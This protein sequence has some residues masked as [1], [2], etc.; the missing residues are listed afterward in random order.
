MTDFRYSVYP[1]NYGEGVTFKDGVLR[2]G[3]WDRTY[4]MPAD[5]IRKLYKALKDHYEPK[6][7]EHP[8]LRVEI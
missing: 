4:N 7:T 3:D 8:F 6:E 5:E 2:F 1:E